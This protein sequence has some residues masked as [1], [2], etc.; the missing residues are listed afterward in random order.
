MVDVFLP[1]M[2]GLVAH[3][4]RRRKMSQGRIASVLGVTQPAVSQCLSKNTGSYRRKLHELGIDEDDVDRYTSILCEDILRNP[5]EGIQTYLSICKGLLMR[6]YLCEAHRREAP[7]LVSCDACNR[8]FGTTKIDEV[9]RTALE[10]LERAGDMLSA[11]S[12]FTSLMPEVSVNL[13][14]ATDGA[15]SE[16][17]VAGFPGRIVRAKGRAQPTMSPEFGASHHMAQMLLK[18]MRF[19][20]D[21]RAAINVKYDPTVEAALVE[22]KLKIGRTVRVEA[23]ARGND[24]V[25]ESLARL[26]ETTNTIPSVVVDEGSKGLEPMTY[27]F[28]GDSIGVAE[29]AIALSRNYMRLKPKSEGP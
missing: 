22:M 24:V 6:G 12:S 27:L 20:P 10:Q 4:L 26:A 5:V 16:A 18:A 28:G 17:D 14:M 25:V 21:I 15:A 11:S 23:V 13:V 7:F 1:S 9:R 3:E 2:R 8:V 19:D 29:R